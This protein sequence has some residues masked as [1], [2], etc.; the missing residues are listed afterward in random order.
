MRAG[1]SKMGV[2][3]PVLYKISSR[4]ILLV[5]MPGVQQKQRGGG[6]SWYFGFK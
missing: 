1:S 6:M 3:F 2:G 4:G 5:T